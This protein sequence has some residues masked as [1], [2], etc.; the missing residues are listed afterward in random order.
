MNLFPIWENAAIRLFS[1]IERGLRDL[2]QRRETGF[3]EKH[4]P[5]PRSRVSA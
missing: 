3:V 5:E 4:N 1:L 2:A